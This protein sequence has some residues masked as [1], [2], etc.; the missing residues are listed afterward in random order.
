MNM[1][2]NVTSRS[3]SFDVH[4]KFD[5][6]LCVFCLEL[7]QRIPRGKLVRRKKHKLNVKHISSNHKKQT[8]NKNK[9]KKQILY[10]THIYKA[11]EETSFPETRAKI[12]QTQQVPEKI[13]RKQKIQEMHFFAFCFL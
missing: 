11:N 10:K 12:A 6:C 13:K 9:S 1:K 2:G 4:F 3:G 8:K 5:L 7:R